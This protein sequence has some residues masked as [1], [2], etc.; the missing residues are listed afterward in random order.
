[1]W[2]ALVVLITLLMTDSHSV[3]TC[4]YVS[5]CTNEKSHQ[6]SRDFSSSWD[7]QLHDFL[8]ENKPDCSD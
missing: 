5:I 6:I 4:P 3:C 2:E 1:M 7:D 8:M